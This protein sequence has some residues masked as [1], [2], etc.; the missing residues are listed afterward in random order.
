MMTSM[1]TSMISVMMIIMIVTINTHCYDRGC[2]EI[3]RVV[4]IV[5]GRIIGYINR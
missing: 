4:C 2:P 3:G 1:I 5:I